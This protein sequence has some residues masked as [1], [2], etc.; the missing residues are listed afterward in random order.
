MVT[1]AKQW[2][3]KSKTGTHELTLPS[4]NVALCQPIKPEAFLESGMIPDPLMPMITKAINSK[5]GLP[6]SKVNEIA[7]DPKQLASAIEMFD[8]VLVYCVIEP[9]VDMPPICDVE[10]CTATQFGGDGI[11]ID[12]AKDGYHRYI[13]P[14]RDESIL[15]ADEV[16]MEDKQHIF[17]WAIG[18]T[19]DAKKFRGQRRATVDAASRG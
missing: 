18:G 17:T 15:Y 6:P 5:R 1:N 3:S 12:R 14:V 8:R 11:H 2:K 4:G 16:D 9:A 19:A 10:G 7:E 13:D